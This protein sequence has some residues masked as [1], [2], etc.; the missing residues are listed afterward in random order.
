MNWDL[1]RLSK[2]LKNFPD[3]LNI[4]CPE[5]DNI[6]DTRDIVESAR[7]KL[8][9]SE[10]TILRDIDRKL[11][12]HAELI[13]NILDNPI[14]SREARKTPRTHWW[15]YLDEVVRSQDRA[16]SILEIGSPR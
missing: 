15:W 3:D 16:I 6:L 11:L 14:R 4:N 5:M 13:W 9:P 7:A 12:Q 1:N 8:T 10:L 2:W